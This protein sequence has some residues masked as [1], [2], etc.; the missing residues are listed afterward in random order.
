MGREAKSVA[1]GVM[2]SSVTSPNETADID[3]EQD[4]QDL[5]ASLMTEVEMLRTR[6]DDQE[7]MTPKWMTSD[8]M[9]GLEQAQIGS[10]DPENIMATMR[11][12]DADGQADQMLFGTDSH[13]IPPML[14]RRFGPKFK[15]GQ[16]VQVN[17]E[18]IAHGTNRKWESILAEVGS[19]GTGIIKKIV[20]LTDSGE[21]KYQVRVPGLT[22]KQGTGMH[23]NELLPRRQKVTKYV[24]EE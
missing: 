2:E 6:V 16:R 4:L 17:P 13:P 21:W 18:I 5:V 12:R 9:D 20:H 10:Y 3:N 8:E 24:V 23:E 15:L 1:G 11:G 7:S 22:N 14:V 19:A